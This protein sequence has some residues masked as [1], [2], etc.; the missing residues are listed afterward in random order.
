MSD[1]I[2][3]QELTGE[4]RQEVLAFAGLITDNLLQGFNDRDY[5]TLSRDF[6][7]QMKALFTQPVFEQMQRMI[8][9]KIGRYRSRVPAHIQK[10]GP[11]RVVV[12]RA[13]FDR[14]KE[15]ELTLSFM[16]YGNRNLVSGLWFNS[17]K[18][19]EG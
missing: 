9:A 19:R 6:D 14:E 16:K 3:V 4:W 17:P 7:E 8:E 5:H 12:Y 2:E 10:K 13:E 11:Y 18:L 1:P 15:V